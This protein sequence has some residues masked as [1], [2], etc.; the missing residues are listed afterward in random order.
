MNDL[1][2]KNTHKNTWLVPV[3]CLLAG[4]ALTGISTNLAKYAVNIGLTPL[5]FLFWSI[6][7]AAIILLI[8]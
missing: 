7:G 2:N 5:A 8:V 6:T 3:A 1:L 4:G